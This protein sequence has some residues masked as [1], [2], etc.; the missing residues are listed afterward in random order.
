[1][2]SGDDNVCNPAPVNPPPP[3]VCVG[4]APDPRFAALVALD[5]SNF[6]LRF[7]EMELV[8]VPSLA[9]GRDPETLLAQRAQYGAALQARQHA[10]FRGSPNY[11]VDVIDSRHGASFTNVCE[12]TLVELASGKITQATA[13]A[14]LALFECY[15]PVAIAPAEG[16]RLVTAYV[17]SFLDKIADRLD[18]DNGETNSLHLLDPAWAARH[19]PGVNLF[20]AEAD[21]PEVAPRNAGLPATFQYFL[22][23][24]A[25]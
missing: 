22:V 19:E 13:D 3:G 16:H 6:L 14:T 23:P 11:R 21:G 2:T 12:H 25:D 15:V 1:M 8:T 5:A 24:P 7:E 9:M 20:V 4:V 18:D 10:A 17:V